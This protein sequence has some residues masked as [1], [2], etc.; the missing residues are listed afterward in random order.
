MTRTPS[1]VVM[2][3][4]KSDFERSAAN[5]QKKVD[6]LETG[7]KCAKLALG[8]EWCVGECREIW[9]KDLAK[10]EKKLAKLM[11]DD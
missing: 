3:N 8:Q 9:I 11:G 5:W 10:M 2:R 6:V 7:I 4:K 1:T